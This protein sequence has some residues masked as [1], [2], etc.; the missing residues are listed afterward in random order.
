MKKAVK[1]SMAL[2]LAEA[3]RAIERKELP[4][5]VI[6][7]SVFEDIAVYLFYLSFFR[8]K[9]FRLIYILP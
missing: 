1:G 9:R 6:L 4:F 5:L 8:L 7:P 2:I 3:M